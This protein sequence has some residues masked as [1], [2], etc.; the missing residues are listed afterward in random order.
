[1]EMLLQQ[2]FFAQNPFEVPLSSLER[3]VKAA[4]PFYT[5]FDGCLVEHEMSK[6]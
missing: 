2:Q 5:H 4:R 6:P 3:P 1:M